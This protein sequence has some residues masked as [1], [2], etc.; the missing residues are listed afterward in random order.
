MYHA[1]DAN[2][3][4]PHMNSDHAKLRPKKKKSRVESAVG[5]FMNFQARYDQ[6]P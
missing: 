5:A 4:L 6:A 2:E 3:A 1:Q